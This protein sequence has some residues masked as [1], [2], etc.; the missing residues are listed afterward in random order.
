MENHFKPRQLLIL[1]TPQFFPVH[2]SVMLA[3]IRFQFQPKPNCFFVEEKSNFFLVIRILNVGSIAYIKLKLWCAFDV[4]IY[5]YI[6][7]LITSQKV[8][9]SVMP[10][11]AVFQNY[12]ILKDSRLRGN[13]AEGRF[14]TFYECI[15]LANSF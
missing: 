10:A 2:T 15:N 4:C 9:I 1:K 6:P 11:K 5:F 14:V 13:D 3:I 12:P 7:T 8:E